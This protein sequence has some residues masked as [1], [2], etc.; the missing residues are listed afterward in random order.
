MIKKRPFGLSRTGVRI[1]FQTIA[2]GGSG[3]LFV[4]IT[5]NNCNLTYTAVALQLLAVVGVFTAGGE[6]VLPYDL[7]EEYPA[8]ILAIANSLSNLTAISI[9]ILVG[10]ILN[11]Q[12]GSSYRWNIIMYLIGGS[13]LLGSLIFALLVKAEPI[14]L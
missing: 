14:D 7:S 4:L 11:D 9:P 2:S 3:L 13:N 10:L 1:F 8:T 6:T 5:F 12:G